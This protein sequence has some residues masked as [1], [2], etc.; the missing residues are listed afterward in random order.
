LVDVHIPCSHPEIFFSYLS[1][2]VSTLVVGRCRDISN[3]PRYDWLL[4]RKPKISSYARD[5][6]CVAK[7]T[8]ALSADGSSYVADLVHESDCMPVD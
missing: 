1:H 8:W 7:G 4:D 2:F 3:L 5:V 6:N